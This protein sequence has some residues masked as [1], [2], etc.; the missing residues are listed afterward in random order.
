M[1][2]VYWEGME[3]FVRI[4]LPFAFTGRCSGLVTNVM[5]G[6]QGYLA[7]VYICYSGI[8]AVCCYLT[9]IYLGYGL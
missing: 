4:W 1:L 2:V 5:L 7:G 8:R 3:S 9:V 6:G